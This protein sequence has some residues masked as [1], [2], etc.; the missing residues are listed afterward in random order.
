MSHTHTIDFI[1][2]FASP[3]A[4]LAQRVLRSIAE[5]HGASIRI[6]PCLLGGIFKLSGNQSPMAAFAQVKGKLEYENLETQRFIASHHL[7]EF[8]MNPHF[9]INT[10]TLMRGLIAA[11]RSGVA[12]VYVDVVSRAMWEQGE[13][14]DDPA[15][16]QRVWQAGG[17]DAAALL[18]QTQSAE[19]KAELLANTETA[20]QRG[21]FGIPTFFVGSEMFFGKERLAQVEELLTR[22]LET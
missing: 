10:L 11:Q 13:K 7:D 22:G 12:A 17:L 21:V 18:A 4:Y 19:V 3:N 9:P 1:F 2:D 14:M 15:V 16:V 8:K 5:R 20:V 6:L